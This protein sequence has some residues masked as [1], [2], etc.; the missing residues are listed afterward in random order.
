M[1]TQILQLNSLFMAV[2]QNQIFAVNLSEARVFV[3]MPVPGNMPLRPNHVLVQS[4]LTK[5]VMSAAEIK[6][7]IAILIKSVSFKIS[8]RLKNKIN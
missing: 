4:L 3:I 5:W 8:V 6:L 2:L 1:Y 7:G